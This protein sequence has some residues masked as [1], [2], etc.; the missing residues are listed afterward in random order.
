MSS[1]SQQAALSGYL[2]AIGA[3]L[4][5]SGNFIIAR[6]VMEAI[7]P[8]SLAFWRWAIAC[9]VMLPFALPTLLREWS[10]VR[11]NLLYLSS[12]ALLGV[13]VFNTLIYFASHTTDALNLALIAICSPI[14]M[15]VFAH[16]FLRDLVT[17]NKVLGIV[18][19][20]V[21]VLVLITRGHPEMLMHVAFTSGDIWM[22]M[23]A[24]C[25]AVYSILLKKKPEQISQWSFQLSTFVIGLLMLAPLYVW[26][27]TTKAPIQWDSS[28]MM[29]VSYLGV[30]ASF[31]AYILW[32]RAIAAIG[33]SK[34]GMVYYCIPIF[35][36][37]L[38]SLYLGEHIESYH[39]VC[40]VMIISGIVIANMKNKRQLAV[41]TAS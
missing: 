39:L 1:P 4:I 22:L 20:V 21:G 13:A 5:W 14:F 3:T 38:G 23:A 26:E 18:I 36:G 9:S 16:F 10:V 2:F 8:I 7:P 40:G 34:A 11:Q 17:K 27:L 28:L 19:V 31:A 15:M 24:T 6:G 37:I 12:A 35:S 30:F 32:N 25:F 33:P 29:S 41:S